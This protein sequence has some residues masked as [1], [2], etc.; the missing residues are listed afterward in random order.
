MIFFCTVLFK[1][2]FLVY[3]VNC[4]GIGSIQ[5]IYGGLEGF[6]I[7]IGENGTVFIN[8]IRFA[9]YMILA[10]LSVW[11]DACYVLLE[12]LQWL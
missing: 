1:F 12:F 4:D 3:I 10:K 6:V 5:P 2:H 11:E 7:E 9:Q 8:P